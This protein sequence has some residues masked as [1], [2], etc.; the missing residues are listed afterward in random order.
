MKP[1]GIFQSGR[2]IIHIEA[3][4]IQKRR[5]SIQKRRTSIAL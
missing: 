3:R 4:N 2:L 1:P 5:I